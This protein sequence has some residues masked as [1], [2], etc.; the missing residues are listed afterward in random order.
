LRV[1]I[2]DDD[3]DTA[4]STAMLLRLWGHDPRYA[5][6]GPKALEAARDFVPDAFIIDLGM[7]GLDGWELARKLREDSSLRDSLFIAVSGF[8]KDEDRERS[9]VA[10]FHHHLLKP[11]DLDQLRLI[12]ERRAPA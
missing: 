5:V 10:G 11:A 1:L 7:P 4:E 12:I 2:V 9:R 3:G 8:G 6:D